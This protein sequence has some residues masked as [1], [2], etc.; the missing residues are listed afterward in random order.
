MMAKLDPHTLFSIFEK[1]D[2]EIYQEH[3]ELDVLKNPYVLLGMVL[4]GI[5]NY[6]IMCLLYRRNY[7]EEFDK[8]EPTIKYKYYNKLYAYLLRINK[9]EVEDMYKIGEGYE[10]DN[11]MRAISNMCDYYESLE[12]YEKC[13]TIVKY[14]DLIFLKQL[15]FFI[16]NSH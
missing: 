15:E 9:D 13:A 14:K 7:P 3:G 12:E 8:V 10:R 11:V 6:D 16:N 4:R 2:E 1:G 5:E